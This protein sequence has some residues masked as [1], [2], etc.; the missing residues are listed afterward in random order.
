[1]WLLRRPDLCLNCGQS[2]TIWEVKDCFTIGGMHILPLLLELCN[3]PQEMAVTIV[4]LLFGHFELLRGVLT[5]H[6]PQHLREYCT[7]WDTRAEKVKFAS[8]WPYCG[9]G[10]AS[11]CHSITTVIIER[12]CGVFWD[13]SFLSWPL[14]LTSGASMGSSLRLA[15]KLWWRFT[16][17]I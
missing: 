3:V 7:P 1:M 2:P 16:P 11:P 17:L 15:P 5:T 9:S 6:C 8:C 12:L 14:K 10:D 4:P 13:H